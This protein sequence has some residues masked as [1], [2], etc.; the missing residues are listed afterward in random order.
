MKTHSYKYLEFQCAECEFSGETEYTMEVHLGKIHSDIFECGLCD[1]E[2]KD[3]SILEMHLFSCQIYVCNE[4]DD[5]SQ[6]LTDLKKHREKEHTMKNINVTHV[7]QNRVN[8]DEMDAN[9][10]SFNDLF[11]EK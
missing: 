9:D 7:K 1:F 10:Y 8:Q 11:N 2:A 4:C 6:N 5:R 3:K